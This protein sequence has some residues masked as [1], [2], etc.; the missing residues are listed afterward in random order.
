MTDT[1]EQILRKHGLSVP[2]NVP[3]TPEEILQAH[4]LAVPKP[5]ELEESQSCFSKFSPI[6]VASRALDILT[7]PAGEETQRGSGQRGLE[8]IGGYLQHSVAEIAG[9]PGAVPGLIGLGEGLARIGADFAQKNLERTIANLATGRVGAQLL[10]PFIDDAIGD[11]VTDTSSTKP[12]SFVRFFMSEEGRNKFDAIDDPD[13]SDEER[14]NVL[15]SI[16][17]ETDMNWGLRQAIGWYDFGS[18]V[19]GIERV[20]GEIELGKELFGIISTTFIGAPRVLITRAVSAMVKLAGKGAAIQY[21]LH[22][23][24]STPARLFAR[25]LEVSTPFTFPLNKTNIALNAG[26]NTA[27]IDATRY[28]S[29]E[30]AI[31]INRANVTSVTP[32]GVAKTVVGTEFALSV[33]GVNTMRSRPVAVRT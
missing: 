1:S 9:A 32:S 13:L 22:L 29:D 12:T 23:A 21:A 24:K 5:T 18:D 3:K 4:G 26:V 31:S 2:S 25:G 6:T 27:I 30:T 19:A 14:L 28:V 20:P 10:A 33:T 8:S 17:P 15:N 7:T 16:N 11:F